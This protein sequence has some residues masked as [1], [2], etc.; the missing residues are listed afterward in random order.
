MAVD[1]RVDVAVDELVAVLLPVDVL[2]GVLKKKE[3]Y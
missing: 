1:V 2:D 3:R